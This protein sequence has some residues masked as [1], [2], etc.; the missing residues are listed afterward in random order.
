MG[1]NNRRNKKKPWN[2]KHLTGN[3]KHHS[4]FNERGKN[5]HGGM[6][7]SNV[8]NTMYKRIITSS[9]LVGERTLSLICKRKGLLFAPLCPMEIVS[10]GKCFLRISSQGLAQISCL[11]TKTDITRCVEML[12]GILSLTRT[13][14]RPSWMK[15]GNH[16][17]VYFFLFVVL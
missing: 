13:I 7:G 11:E 2:G 15:I 10:L 16:S 14:T 5:K 9:S 8:G 4:Q 17:I 3:F 1:H 12:Y 6:G